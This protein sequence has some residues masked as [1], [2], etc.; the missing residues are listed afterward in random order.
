MA[1]KL[2]NLEVEAKLKA[3]GLTV[4]TPREFQGI[5]DVP[6]KSVSMFIF[7]NVKSGLLLKLRNSLYTLQDSHRDYSFI[8][9]RLY[10]PSYVSLATA[11]S[12]YHLIPETVYATT[13]ITTKAT[14]EFNTPIGLFVYQSIKISA[15]TG[16]RLLT[17]DR[18][19]ALFAEPEKALADYL[20][21]VSLKKISLNDRLNLKPIDR[22]KL[23]KYVGLFQ[24]PDILSLIRKIY[25]DSRQPRT[26]Y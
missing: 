10:Q 13:S 2:Q 6:R 25:A 19:P 15:F 9:N 23:T 26:I 14:R 16:Y 18:Q 8:A 3:L 21:F 4:F 20:Y 22:D 11:M 17:I 1:K 24:R 5:F 7:N 12:Y